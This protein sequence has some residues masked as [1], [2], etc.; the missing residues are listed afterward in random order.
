MCI[1]G[2]VQD[3][4]FVPEVEILDLL[5][6]LMESILKASMARPSS[7]TWPSTESGPMRHLSCS[8]LTV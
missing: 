6:H 7:F 1:D 3:D 5:L 4:F 2:K 8:W